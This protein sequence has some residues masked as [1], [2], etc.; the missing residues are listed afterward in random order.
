MYQRETTM[1]GIYREMKRKRG[2]TG[3]MCLDKKKSFGSFTGI[4]IEA[5]EAH[6]FQMFGKSS[7]KWYKKELCESHQEVQSVMQFNRQG[8]VLMNP[9]VTVIC[10]T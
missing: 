9:N 4:L 10:T 7:L 8:F 3:V 2:L 6:S 1:E 5:Q